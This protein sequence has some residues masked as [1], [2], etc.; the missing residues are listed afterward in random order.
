MFGLQLSYPF[1]TLLEGFNLAQVQLILHPVWP[2]N[3]YLI[4]VEW[5]DI[6]PQPTH[7]RSTSRTHCPNPV[8]GMY[9]VKRSSQS[10]GTHMGDVVPLSQIW[11]ATPL[12]PRYGPQ[13]DPKLTSQN[14]MEFSM[15][16]FLNKFFDKDLYYMIQHYNL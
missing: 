1:L 3:V 14:S 9:V 16:F 6:I 15:E 8:T 5:F 12:I 11:S 13:A 4:Y 7:L 10:N 2:T